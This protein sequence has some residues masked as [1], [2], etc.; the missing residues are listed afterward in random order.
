MLKA[1]K[2]YEELY[3]KTKR[4]IYKGSPT[5]KAKKLHALEAKLNTYAHKPSL[6]NLLLGKF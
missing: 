2:Q 6:N 5:K 3:N 1:E 4:W